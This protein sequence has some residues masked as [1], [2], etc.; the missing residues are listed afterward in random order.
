[1]TNYIV[2]EQDVVDFFSSKSINEAMHEYLCMLRQQIIFCRM[3]RARV[4]NLNNDLFYITTSEQQSSKHKKYMYSKSKIF[5]E[6]E[7]MKM[8]NVSSLGEKTTV[9]T[10]EIVATLINELKKL[11]YANF[12][13]KIEKL[14]VI[15]PIIPV[16]SNSEIF[17]EEIMNI[18]KLESN[19]NDKLMPLIYEPK[20][21]DSNVTVF[22][23]ITVLKDSDTNVMNEEE[24]NKLISDME[25]QRDDQIEKIINLKDAHEEECENY[26]TNMCKINTIKMNNRLYTEWLDVKK[27]EYYGAKNIFDKLK[28]DIINKSMPIP[29][30][31]SNK[32]PLLKFMLDNNLIDQEEEFETYM[33]LDYNLNKSASFTTNNYIEH[34][35]AYISNNDLLNKINE[36][37]RVN[38]KNFPSIDEI[39]S[40]LDK[41]NGKLFKTSIFKEDNQNEKNIL[42]ASD[43]TEQEMTD[44]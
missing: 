27:K 41:E 43:D 1:M 21:I 12:P 44:K 6:L 4:I 39:F 5:F 18:K 9:T 7:S 32:Y 8:V 14:S 11:I 38:S 31:F 42:A 17:K 10:N 2:Y 29:V 16:K 36:F 34:H 28:D 25:K 33:E 30:L 40:K 24:F 35:F 20:K 23:D 26:S 22:E 13:S 15:N 37:I 3:N 19:I